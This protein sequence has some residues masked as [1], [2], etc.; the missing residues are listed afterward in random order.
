MFQ[1][2][3][4]E[5]KENWIPSIFRLD[6]EDLRHLFAQAITGAVGHWSL[7]SRQQAWSCWLKRYSRERVRDNVASPGFDTI[8]VQNSLLWLQHLPFAFP[9]AVDLAM[10]MHF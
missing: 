5:V 10:A 2:F 8:E 1:L 3:P 7:Q 4:D 9:D 6:D